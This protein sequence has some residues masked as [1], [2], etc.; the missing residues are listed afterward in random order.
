MLVIQLAL[1]LRWYCR[2]LEEQQRAR[3]TE[4]ARKATDETVARLEELLKQQRV[5]YLLRPLY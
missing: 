2:F 3:D 5:N 4:S 1:P